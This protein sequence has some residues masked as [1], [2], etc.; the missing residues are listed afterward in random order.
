MDTVD[1]S[2]QNCIHRVH[3]LRRRWNMGCSGSS[4]LLFSLV[5]VLGH[6]HWE[7]TDDTHCSNGLE[8]RISAKQQQVRSR[9]QNNHS[10]VTIEF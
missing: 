9:P 8:H 1:T 3:L 4:L 6:D 2:D 7:G 5:I 10:G